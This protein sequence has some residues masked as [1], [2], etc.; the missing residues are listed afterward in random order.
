MNE[1]RKIRRYCRASMRAGEAKGTPRYSRRVEIEAKRWERL[2]DRMR[3]SIKDPR[4][5]QGEAR[6]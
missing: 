6:P 5:H 4:T 2:P 1:L 3:V